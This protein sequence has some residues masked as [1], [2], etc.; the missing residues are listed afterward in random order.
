[1]FLISVHSHILY[2]FKSF[3]VVSSVI[4]YHWCLIISSVKD[5]HLDPT[6]FSCSP[7]NKINWLG[8]IKMAFIKYYWLHLSSV[9]P[10]VLHYIEANVISSLLWFKQTILLC[11]CRF[12]TRVYLAR[13]VKL[14]CYMLYHHH[15]HHHLFLKTHIR[16]F[17]VK[18]NT[19]GSNQWKSK[20][21]I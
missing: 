9:A 6:V 3:I 19:D 5:I 21:Y 18:K 7:C 1:M 20:I 15:H 2:H 10:K 12:S 16:S 11:F 14:I 8:S 17:S 13:Q 4:T